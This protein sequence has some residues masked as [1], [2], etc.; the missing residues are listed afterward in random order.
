MSPVRKSRRDDLDKVHHIADISLD[1]DYT[2]E[3]FIA[4]K[5]MWGDG[6]LVYEING[7]IVGFICGTILDQ[8]SVRVLMLAVHPL[9]RN[10]GIGSELLQRF[11]GVS[12]SMGATRVVLEVRVSSP[13]AIEFYQ[14]RGFQVTDKLEDFYTNGEDGYKMVR[15][16]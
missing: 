16:L 2:G 6:F 3:L 12:S 5:E 1:E 9:Y 13:K 11:V 7:R 15:Y 14:K 4:I 8:K 10:R